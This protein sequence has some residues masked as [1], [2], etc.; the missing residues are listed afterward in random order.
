[1][2][3]KK[4]MHSM[5][6][7]FIAA[8]II[9]VAVIAISLPIPMQKACTEEAK[10]CPDGSAVGR[11]GQNC[12]FTPCPTECNV[13]SDCVPKE[14]CHPTSCINKALKDVCNLACTAVCEGPLDCG[15]GSCGCV[16]NKCTTVLR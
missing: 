16:G 12:E 13:D 3:K 7:Y 5:K 1:M 2:A 15:A 14:C 8:A 11:T 4:H 6:C 10:I 9:L